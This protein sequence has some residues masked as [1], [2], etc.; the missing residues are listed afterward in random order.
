MSRSISMD[1]IYGIG[2][3]TSMVLS[4]FGAGEAH[5]DGSGSSFGWEQAGPAEGGNLNLCTRHLPDTLDPHRSGLSGN[6][7]R[8]PD[9][10]RQSGRAAT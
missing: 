10:L 5:H 1:E 8:N 2:S 7:T 3:S 6:G 4:G 9:D